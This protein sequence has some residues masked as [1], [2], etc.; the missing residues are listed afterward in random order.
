VSPGLGFVLFLGVTLAGLGGA[1]V[2]G[3]AA[4]RRLHFR[5]VATAVVG[6]GATIYYAEKMGEFYDLEAAGWVYPFHLLIAKVTI[7]SYLVVIGSGLA[8]IKQS[9]RRRTHG[10]IAYSVIVL[11]V[12]TAITG[13]WMILAAT[14][15]E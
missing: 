13:T 6:L 12:L 7:A 10:R 9:S 2:T 8:T 4:K 11:T 14:P 1:V 5:W 15:L 3:R